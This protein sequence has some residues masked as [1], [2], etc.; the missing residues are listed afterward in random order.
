MKLVSIDTRCVDPMVVH[1]EVRV[2]VSSR[3]RSVRRVVQIIQPSLQSVLLVLQK[4]VVV[5]LVLVV[6]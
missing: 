5:V 3:H 1:D 4:V 6:V 2:L